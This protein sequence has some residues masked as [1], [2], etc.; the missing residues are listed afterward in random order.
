MCRAFPAAPKQI[1]VTMRVHD[2]KSG[3]V[4]VAQLAREPE[5]PV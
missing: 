2:V 3:P 5:Y 4:H 1:I